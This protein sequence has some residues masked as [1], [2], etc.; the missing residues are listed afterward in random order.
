M[1]KDTIEELEKLIESLKNI[2]DDKNWELAFEDT[3]GRL[4]IYEQTLK[5]V[6]KTAFDDVVKLK[7]GRATE[8][9][10]YRE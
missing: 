4:D 9:G 3:N 2:V 1:G 6:I 10:H 5:Q 7:V 8:D